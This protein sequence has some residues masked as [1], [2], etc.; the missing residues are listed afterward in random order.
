MLY[1]VYEYILICDRA[2]QAWN[3]RTQI[4]KNQTHIKLSVLSVLKHKLIDGE[5]HLFMYTFSD[6]FTTHLKT[7]LE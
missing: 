5:N 4:K 2:G 1:T 6:I 3:S 7:L